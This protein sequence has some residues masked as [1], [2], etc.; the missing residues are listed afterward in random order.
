MEPSK[1]K[2]LIEAGL[3][4]A[5]VEVTGDGRHF[6]AVV[7]SKAFEGKS[8]IQRHRMV[9]DTVKAQV[10]SDEL[11]ALSIKARTE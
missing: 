3:P 4:G 5:H 2:E 10:A 6:E 9:M 7:V 1:V 8:L 11:H